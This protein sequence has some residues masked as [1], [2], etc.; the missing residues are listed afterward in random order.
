MPKLPL[1]A[2]HVVAPAAATKKQSY[3][4]RPAR[5]ARACRT[6]HDALQRVSWQCGISCRLVPVS[7]WIVCAQVI[8]DGVAVFDRPLCRRHDP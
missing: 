4:M 8:A 3:S 2:D 7:G 6:F 5:T 1:F